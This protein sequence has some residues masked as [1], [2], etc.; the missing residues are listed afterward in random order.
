MKNHYHKLSD[1]PTHFKRLNSVRSS[2]R[3]IKKEKRTSA[4]KHCVMDD[5][6]LTM[7]NQLPN[8][9]PP[10]AA[11]LLHINLPESRASSKPIQLSNR[12]KSQEL[13]ATD[14]QPKQQQTSAPITR[15]ATIRK[16]SVWA[17]NVASKIDFP[18]KYS[19]QFMLH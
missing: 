2:L 7:K 15:T 11:A 19:S 6:I 4:L 13:I 9:I 14:C 3:F 1:S 8:H 5:E 12:T 17:N 10:K 16:K 18:P